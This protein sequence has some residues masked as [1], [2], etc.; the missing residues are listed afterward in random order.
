MRMTGIVLLLLSLAGSVNVHAEP[1]DAGAATEAYLAKMSPDQRAKSDAYFEGGTWL[2]LWSFLFGA[3]VSLVLLFGRVSARMRDLAQRVTRFHI[4]HVF[5]YFVLYT[6][7]TTAILFPLTLYAGYFREHKYGLSNQNLGA[8]TVEMLKGLGIS[9]VL[10]GL[11]MVGIYAILRKATRR[12]WLYGAVASI[13]FLSFVVAIGPVF[14]APMFNRYTLLTDER[15]RQPILA[16]AHA[17]GIESNNVYVMDASKQTK[18]VSANVSGMFGTER[19][20]LN[21]NLLNR[22][23]LP[24]IK[25]VMGHEIGHYALGHLYSMLIY[26]GI[27]I[28]VV[29][30]FMQAASRWSLARWGERWGFTSVSDAAS[31]PLLVLLSSIAFFVLTPVTN[32]I[33][34]V[35]EVEADLFGLNTAREPEGFAEVSLKLGEYRKL[36]P[37]PI[38]E[39]LFFDHP[40]GRNRIL[41][42]MRWK[43]AMMPPGQNAVAPKPQESRTKV[44]DL[45]RFENP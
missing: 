42:A 14:L 11:A 3:A 39:F 27:L 15:V 12:W 35:Q 30:A 10:G 13:L 5:S 25:A 43:A 33:I 41:M 20:T 34:R 21:D 23:S 26:V 40:S 38:E 4:V 6:A 17:N 22:T 9:V 29:F 37:G 24:E 44:R 1:F 2:Q 32:T 45:P 18:R 28:V 36:A 19:V 7:L 31:L 16:M 8:W